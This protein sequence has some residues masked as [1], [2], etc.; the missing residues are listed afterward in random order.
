MT[1]YPVLQPIV[2][3]NVLSNFVLFF[4]HSVYQT[5]NIFA[6]V[7]ER[8]INVRLSDVARSQCW[9][10]EDQYGF[11]SGVS[12]TD[13]LMSCTIDIECELNAGNAVSSISLDVAKVYDSVSRQ[14]IEV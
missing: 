4:S 8:C 1:E 11:Q 6:R 13:A 10:C 2:A 5:S 14:A 12:T 9:L 3:P 7:F